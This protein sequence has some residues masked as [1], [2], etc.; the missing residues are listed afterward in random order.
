MISRILR[1]KTAPRKT[2]LFPIKSIFVDRIQAVDP[3]FL[4]CI[5]GQLSYQSTFAHI[6]LKEQWKE[7]EEMISQSGFGWLI[8]WSR[9]LEGDPDD[10]GHISLLPFQHL[11]VRWYELGCNPGACEHGDAI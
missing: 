5:H 8:V 1:E 11:L 3:N 2:Y 7:I 4:S 10:S 9:H 6:N